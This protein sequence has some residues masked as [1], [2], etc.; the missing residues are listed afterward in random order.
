MLVRVLNAALGLDLASFE[1]ARQ[2]L[3]SDEGSEMLEAWLE[4]HPDDSGDANGLVDKSAN[5][6]VT[7]LAKARAS[8]L[9]VD[10]SDRPHQLWCPGG[11]P[12]GP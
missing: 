7:D 4:S 11:E 2:F 8:R 6:L 12:G 3:L 1:E 5:T 9:P 10:L